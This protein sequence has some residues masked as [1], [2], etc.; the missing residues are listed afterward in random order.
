[1]GGHN[2]IIMSFQYCYDYLYS[3]LIIL[4]SLFN[5]NSAHCT[6]SVGEEEGE[7]VGEKET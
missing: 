3:A 1:M 6:W 5:I 4:I 2:N 7:G